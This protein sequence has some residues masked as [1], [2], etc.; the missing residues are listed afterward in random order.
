[1][2]RMTGKLIGDLRFPTGCHHQWWRQNCCVFLISRLLVSAGNDRSNEVTVR[3]EAKEL[4]KRLIKTQKRGS[5]S[6][7]L[8]H[9]S[10]V[11]RFLLLHVIYHPPIHPIPS[12][13]PFISKNLPLQPHDLLNT[14][15][16]V[17]GYKQSERRE[18]DVKDYDVTSD[19]RRLSLH[20][21]L[22]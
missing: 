12:S 8:A 21:G 16:S 2:S 3:F 22:L 18:N 13:Q 20:F 5:L 9:I 14:S 1:M 19:L 10:C 7:T 6:C 17:F 15:I 11:K 4:R